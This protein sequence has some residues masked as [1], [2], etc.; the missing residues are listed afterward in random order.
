VNFHL[1]YVVD[2]PV[3]YKKSVRAVRSLKYFDPGK[4]YMKTAEVAQ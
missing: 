2:S 3:T 4:K 1:G